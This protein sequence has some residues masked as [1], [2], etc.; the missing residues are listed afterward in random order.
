MQFHAGKP[1]TSSLNSWPDK[2]SLD[3]HI[4]LSLFSHLL[5][6]SLSLFHS[7][8]KAKIKSHLPLLAVAGDGPLNVVEAL[9][10]AKIDVN[11]VHATTGHT[12]LHLAAKAGRA[13]ILQLILDK[14]CACLL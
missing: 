10:E 3:T 2:N 9:L 11:Q 4:P 14:V 6:R 7:G 12:A 5:A 1:D 13:D 8:A